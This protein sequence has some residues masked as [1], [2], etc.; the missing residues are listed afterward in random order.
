MAGLKLTN[1][2]IPKEQENNLRQN[3]LYKDIL[4]DLRS[5]IYL[6]RE[7]NQVYPLNDVQALYDIE[8]V[9]TSIANCFL[10]SPGQRVLS[11]TYGI[12]LRRYIFEDV[13]ADTAYFI[14]EDILIFLP[15]F[16]PRV[17]IKGVVVRPDPDNQQYDIILE[18]DVPSLRAFGVTITNYL[19]T[20]GY[21]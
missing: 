13:S 12:D 21:Y 14:R 5:D 20:T 9:K 17:V 19:K 1:I 10:T 18:I 16:E 3:Y 6:K 11:P 15:Q 7:I 8:A 2:A 4:L